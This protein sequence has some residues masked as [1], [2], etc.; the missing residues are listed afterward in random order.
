[1]PPVC[2]G[3]GVG[4]IEAA[5]CS[6]KAAAGDTGLLED[7]D[8]GDASFNETSSSHDTGRN[9]HLLG[10]PEELLPLMRP[11]YIVLLVSLVFVMLF[12][13]FKQFS[14]GITDTK[15]PMWLLIGGNFLNFCFEAYFLSLI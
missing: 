11:Y 7:D 2:K 12:N 15:T 9:I 10:Q 1:M 4:V 6:S 5:V 14:D 8:I 3:L 13:A